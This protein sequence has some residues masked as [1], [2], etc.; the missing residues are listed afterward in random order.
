LGTAAVRAN[1]KHGQNSQNNGDRTRQHRRAATP[2]PAGTAVDIAAS[3]A[4]A[5][6]SPLTSAI[7]SFA[8]K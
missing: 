8:L 4:P 5:A 3:S 6:A 1:H 7:R 2:A